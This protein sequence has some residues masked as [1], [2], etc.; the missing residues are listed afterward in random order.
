[1]TK[2]TKQKHNLNNLTKQTNKSRKQCR[3]SKPFC[4]KQ[5]GNTFSNIETKHRTDEQVREKRGFNR[6]ISVAGSKC[7]RETLYLPRHSAAAFIL[8]KQIQT[9]KDKEW[10]K[11]KNFI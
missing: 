8:C 4:N 2:Q 5:N 6:C 1:M 7:G 9:N 10:K 3:N 11:T